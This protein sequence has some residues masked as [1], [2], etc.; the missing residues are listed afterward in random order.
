MENGKTEARVQ[1]VVASKIRKLM[2]TRYGASM[3]GEVFKVLSGHVENL[4]EKAWQRTR[5][6][7]RKTVMVRDVLDE[8]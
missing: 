4:L 1:L 2:K 6:K 8:S 3:S 5:A 7:G